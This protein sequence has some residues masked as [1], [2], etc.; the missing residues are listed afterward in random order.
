[1]SITQEPFKTEGD[2]VVKRQILKL[3]DGSFA[4]KNVRAFPEKKKNVFSFF[5]ALF[6]LLSIDRRRPLLQQSGCELLVVMS[7]CH[8]RKQ[9]KKKT[10]RKNE[11]GNA[12]Q[13]KR[14]KRQKE[15]ERKAAATSL[16][17]QVKG[18]TT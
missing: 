10:E 14:R 5:S 7:L 17:N 2:R 8:E 15:K 12:N 11:G 18:L 4:I 13:K 6:L 1:M 16:T 3:T 9:K